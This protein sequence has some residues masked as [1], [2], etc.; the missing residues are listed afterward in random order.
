MTP[1]RQKALEAVAAAARLDAR[2]SGISGQLAERLAALDA[3]PPDPA[4]AR[5]VVEVRAVVKR[6]RNTGR[7]FTFGRTGETDV[8]LV[9]WCNGY[10][11]VCFLTA[12]V[13]LPTAPTIAATVL[14]LTEG[15]R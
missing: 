14:P 15:G 9:N 2:R 11:V 8:A 10:E 1:E 5:E 3:L 4:P 13:P 7:L 6:D 12:R